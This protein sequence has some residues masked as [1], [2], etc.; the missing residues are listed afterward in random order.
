MDDHDIHLSDHHATRTTSCP[1]IGLGLL[2][3]LIDM[4][5]HHATQVVKYS[6]IAAGFDV[7]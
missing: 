1:Y 3:H 5:H 7:M 2:G 4:Q 6:D